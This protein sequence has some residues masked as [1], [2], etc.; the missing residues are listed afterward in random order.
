MRVGALDAHLRK[1]PCLAA[2]EMD[3][4]VDLRRVRARA[5]DALLVDQ[6]LICLSDLALQSSGTDSLLNFH[7]LF[8]PL[9]FHLIGKGTG[10]LVCGGAIDRR[11][12]EAADSIK[13]C[14]FQ[15]IN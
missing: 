8:L 14:F 6:Y 5:T 13:I 3:P 1:L 11:V 10:K 7:E 9:A 15:K 12:L 4:A 2:L